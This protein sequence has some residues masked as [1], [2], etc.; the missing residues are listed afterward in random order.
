MNA[1]HKSIDHV[2]LQL[3]YSVRYSSDITRFGHKFI[4]TSEAIEDDHA[5]VGHQGQKDSTGGALALLEK[6][7]RL[8]DVLLRKHVV[9]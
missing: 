7:D 8:Y 6:M 4:D 5:V 1:L 3:D 9:E 2:D